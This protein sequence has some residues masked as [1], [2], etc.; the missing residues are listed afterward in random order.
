MVGQ[1]P[2]ADNPNGKEVL[3]EA[4]VAELAGEKK[5]APLVRQ[6]VIAGASQR[7]LLPLLGACFRSE[8]FDVAE[9]SM[10]NLRLTKCALV[11]LRRPQGFLDRAVGVEGLIEVESLRAAVVVRSGRVIQPVQFVGRLCAAL[12]QDRWPGRGFADGDHE[13]RSKLGST[14]AIRSHEAGTNG[15]S[16]HPQPVGTR[17]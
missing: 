1:G 3:L 9:P 4:L 6:P 15:I 16:T 2:S 12:P 14:Q 8:V 11:V 7:V 5:I 10:A 17:R 13:H